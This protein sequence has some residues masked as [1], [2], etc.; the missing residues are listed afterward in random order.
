MTWRL[1]LEALGWGLLSA[2]SLPLGC[3]VGL[4]RANM[5][6]TLRSIAM[7]FGAGALLFA[8]SLSLFGEALFHIAHYGRWAVIVM[9][10]CAMLG[11]LA[12]LALNQ[13]LETRGAFFRSFALK[14]NYFMRLLKH[15]SDS[16]S[17]DDEDE[18]IIEA[19]DIIQPPSTQTEYLKEKKRSYQN[20][21]FADSVKEK[22]KE[23]EK[24]EEKEKG[25]RKYK[26]EEKES[27][28][29]TCSYTPITNTNVDNNNS[30]DLEKQPLRFSRAT[31]RERRKTL[32]QSI[33]FAATEDSL[34]GTTDKT[35]LTP[36]SLQELDP[37][38]STSNVGLAI[39]LG[40]LIDSFP[41]SLV[42]GILTVSD[43]GMSYALI[44]AVF[45]S[46]FP[47]ALSS[48]IIMLETGLSNLK[49]LGLWVSIT[50]TTGIGACIGSFLEFDNAGPDSW[51]FCLLRGIEGTAA[52][53]MLV[54][55]TNTMLPEAFAHG[56][57]WTGLAALVGF[58]AALAVELS[59]TW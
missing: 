2:V 7:A 41:E 43:R 11:G 53:A 35:L 50:L 45:L 52:G 38:L 56:G 18:G 48:S 1:H 40:I 57:N 28:E 36:E 26:E 42:I 37:E 27:E 6:L 21:T 54:M 3:L 29:E 8:L 15:E 34:Y 55:I 9:I 31:L 20:L 33:A 25:K 59:V 12:F 47:E 24:E 32:R 44:L 30:S 4:W 13:I 58:I 23:K 22:Q 16:D 14:K 17:G 49:I 10:A 5:P 46:N 51:E 39:W 19:K